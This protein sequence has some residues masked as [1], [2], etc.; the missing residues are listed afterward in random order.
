MK[1]YLS[2][3]ILSSPVSPV[4]YDHSCRFLKGRENLGSEATVI[5]LLHFY[6]G[7]Q[8][9]RKVFDTFCAIKNTASSR[10]FFQETC[11]YEA[12]LAKILEETCKIKRFLQDS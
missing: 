6:R 12:I 2:K 1:Q 4:G 11:K 9:F 7:K 5:I 3:V 8:K 10:Q